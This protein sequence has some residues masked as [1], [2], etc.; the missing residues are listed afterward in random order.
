MKASHQIQ[1]QNMYFP[2]VAIFSLHKQQFKSV[3]RHKLEETILWPFGEMKGIVSPYCG[4]V[5]TFKAGPLL[6]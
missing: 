2:V 4:E 6:P 3:F 5:E 1:R